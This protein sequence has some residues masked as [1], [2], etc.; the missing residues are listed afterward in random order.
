M[1]L[2]GVDPVLDEES[3]DPFER[4]DARIQ[5]QR[6]TA[7]ELD[8]IADETD[9]LASSI[10]VVVR[11]TVETSV[12][13]FQLV[14]RGTSVKTAPIVFVLVSNPG[15]DCDTCYGEFL[16]RT[17]A[18]LPIFRRAAIVSIDLPGL[19]SDAEES[20]PPAPGMVLFA[21]LTEGVVECLSSEGVTSAVGIGTHAGAWLLFNAQSRNPALFRSLVLSGLTRQAPQ[22]GEAMTLAALSWTLAMYGWTAWARA[23]LAATLTSQPALR[24][25]VEVD[26][27]RWQAD[28]VAA[29]LAGWSARPVIDDE[30]LREAVIGVR[31]S[32]GSAL[33]GTIL[34][35]PS[36]P[37]DGV[38]VCDVSVGPLCSPGVSRMVSRR[39]L[40][41]RGRW[42]RF[43]R[44]SRSSSPSKATAAR[45]A[46]CL[47]PAALSRSARCPTGPSRR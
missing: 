36:S 27:D 18:Q 14:V 33:S 1:Q 41:I 19:M 24:K 25:R 37:G 2:Q 39:A 6:R 7:D 9:K 31:G 20:L 11:K 16:S 15:A 26:T 12:G 30:G 44:S 42:T 32:I 45:A 23:T 34:L 46:S 29:L 5:S 13:R 47:C 10:D 40:P 3:P 38:G 8:R 21:R 43:T 22:S 4:R 35:Q 17:A 28:W